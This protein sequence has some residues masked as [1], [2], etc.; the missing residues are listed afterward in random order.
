MD[1]GG[2]AERDLDRLA[3]VMDAEVRA[4]QADYERMAL[5]AQWRERSLADVAREWMVRGDV[6][7]VR[8]AGQQLTGTVVHVGVD[9]AVL[10][11]TRGHVDLALPRLQGLRVVQQVRSGGVPPGRG[12]RTFRA[13]L[14]EHEVA[15][16]RLCLLTSADDLVDGMIEAV[17]ADHLLVATRRGQVVLPEA[18]VVAAWPAPLDP[19]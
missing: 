4:E 9:L 3:A 14:T 13:R 17:A 7:E 1:V 18:A 12:A 2:S 11:A 8:A 15:A 5:Q 6:V 10:A 19:R 16:A